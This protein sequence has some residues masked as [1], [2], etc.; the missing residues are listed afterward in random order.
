MELVLSDDDVRTLREILEGYLP[1]LRREA[2]RT[3]LGEARE[4]LRTLMK[5][6]DLCERLL[7][8]L[9]SS[10]PIRT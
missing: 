9:E 10:H 4:L 2:A 5:R 1:D 3:H 6:R 8:E 7:A